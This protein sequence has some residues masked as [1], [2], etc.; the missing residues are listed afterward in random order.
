LIVAIERESQDKPLTPRGD[1][2]IE[3]N[4]LL[5]IYSSRGAESELTDIFGHFEDHTV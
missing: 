3:A 2:R 5:T 1:T 4:D